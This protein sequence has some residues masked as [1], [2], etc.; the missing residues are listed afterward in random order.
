MGRELATVLG[1][2]LCYIQPLYSHISISEQKR[3]QLEKMG[4]VPSQRGKRPEAWELEP[5]LPP[6]G[7]GAPGNSLPNSQMSLRWP[8]PP[9]QCPLS[10][11]QTFNNACAQ[12][13]CLACKESPINGSGLLP[14]PLP[15]TLLSGSNRC[16]PEGAM[17]TRMGTQI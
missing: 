11:I 15:G 9:R 6:T 14:S 17:V 13:Q 5:T 10:L 7:S 8:C 1:A 4:Q 16:G 12:L 3:A 2:P